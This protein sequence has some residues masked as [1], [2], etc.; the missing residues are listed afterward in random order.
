MKI[1]V[2]PGSFDPITYGHIDIIDRASRLFD[3]VIVAVLNNPSKAPLF[4]T[5]ERMDMIRNATSELR[6]VEVDSFSGLLIDYVDQKGANTVLKGLR[7]VSDFEYE[8]QMALMNRKL[9]RN[10]ETIFMMTSSRYSFLSSSLVKEVARLG[11]CVKELVPDYVSEKLLE[12][13]K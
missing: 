7:A 1:A 11:G 5:E 2:Y 9:N 3:N 12:K 6:N 10:V 8:L 4:D 13:N